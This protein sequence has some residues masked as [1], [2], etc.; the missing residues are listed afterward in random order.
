MR[1]PQT[2]G[3]LNPVWPVTTKVSPLQDPP[4][5]GAPA[6]IE[7][8]GAFRR[9][10]SKSNLIW[11]SQTC[12]F[13]MTHID[14]HGWKSRRGVAQT[15]TKIP[16]VQCFLDKIWR[17]FIWLFVCILINKFF[18]CLG[19]WGGGAPM[20]NC[21]THLPPSPASPVFVSSNFLSVL[22]SNLTT[23]CFKSF[24]LLF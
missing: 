4:R 8:M 21:L 9:K 10:V 5:K 20:Y 22:F 6:T 3:G 16:G 13:Y 1:V 2:V 18:T 12:Y 14:G 17:D 11:S 24:L 15:F 19:S 23:I 7:V